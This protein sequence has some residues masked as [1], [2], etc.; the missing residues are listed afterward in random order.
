M[1]KPLKQLQKTHVLQ[2]DQSD[3]GVACLLG[4]INY[5][6]GEESLES[7][8]KLSG[9]SRQGTTLLGLYQAATHLGFEAQGNEA[10][11]QALID[12][13][14]PVILHVIME[15]KRQHYVICYG[16][17]NDRFIIGDP[18]KG[19]DHYT[20]EALEKIWVSKTCLT[21]EPTK[22]F[23]RLKNKTSNKKKWFLQTIKKDYR[24][25][26]FS[27]L[28]GVVIAVLGMTMA[29]FSQKLIDDI[30][31]SKNLQKLITGLALV[32][33]L[34]FVRIGFNA[35]RDYFLIR[36]S[37]DFNNR[38]IDKFYHSLLH[39][40]K[41]F[42]DTRKIGELVARLNDTQ[43]I[44][45]VIN[46]IVGNVVIDILVTLTSL[47]LIFIYS[48]QAA[49]IVL[50]S[51]PLYG[52]LLYRFNQPIIQSQKEVMSAYAL[53][54]SN[55]ISSMSGIES[56]KNNNKQS[57]F[58]KTNQLIYGNYQNKAF[59]LGKINIKLS[60]Y[61]SLFSTLFLVGI[62]SYGSIEVYQDR[63]QLGE[64]M[65]I[66]GVSGSLL[67]SVANLA[68]ISIALNEAKVAFNR[69]YDF[70]SIPP[71]SK[72]KLTVSEFKKIEAKNISFRFP[73][74]SLLFQNINLSITKGECVV[75]VGESGSG[76]STISSLFQKTYLPSTGDIL[77][78]NLYQLDDV[79]TEDWR[80]LMGIVPQN[81]QVF[82]TNLVANVVMDEK[83]DPKA[84][85]LFCH[86][87]GFIPFLQQLPQGAATIL[88][89]EGINLSGGQ[90]QMLGLM[91]ALYNKPQ[92][93]LLDEFT[94]AMDRK[95]EAIALQIIQQLKKEI[96]V[97]FITHRLHIVPKVADK[98]YVLE[99]KNTQ[100]NG[101]HQELCKYAN[102]YS[103]FWKEIMATSI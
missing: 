11:L 89:E 32:A 9:T 62:L 46:K 6:E 44:Q 57:I 96:G 42:F 39:L 1:I 30:L 17:E 38:I 35:L 103:D 25:I 98:I 102:F 24:I 68:L 41:A 65:A 12:H 69:M 82:N 27:L 33:F 49:L 55:Y 81:I 34:L 50:L 78:N 7:L 90:Q 100:L 72:G 15:E 19:I 93:L 80:K 10:D 75:L 77:V 54:E 74:H 52:I 94:S 45:R 83:I 59:N 79:K 53:N 91:R 101:S 18:A 63:L 73:G 60:V 48:W 13:G 85:E 67:P 70:A 26:S 84:F 4:L 88:G 76:K 2:Q 58:R 99:N 8:R 21:L 66:L 64:L 56:I 87:Y 36:Q 16:F 28:L 61:S 31:P 37:K 14:K 23:L 40:P 43:R 29:V 5:Y 95:T 3:C 92:F 20:K 51:L 71:E 47:G 97:L 86:Q 22:E